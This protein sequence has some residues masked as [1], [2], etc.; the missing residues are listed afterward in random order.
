MSKPHN[1]QDAITFSGEMEGAIWRVRVTLDVPLRSSDDA[2][3][4]FLAA[5]EAEVRAL[6]KASRK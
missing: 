6:V 2:R 5:V 1:E 3:H 4:K